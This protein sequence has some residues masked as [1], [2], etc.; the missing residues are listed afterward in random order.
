MRPAPTKPT[1]ISSSGFIGARGTGPD[2]PFRTKVSSA[3][4]R[5]CNAKQEGDRVRR[6]LQGAVGRLVDHGYA[7][8]LRRLQVDRVDAHTGAPDHPDARRQR[9]DVRRPQRLKGDYDPEGPGGD[10]GQ[11]ARVGKV[12]ETEVHLAE[13]F[14]NPV[15]VAENAFG[16][17]DHGPVH[18]LVCRG[19]HEHVLNR[20]RPPPG[21]SALSLG[22]MKMAV[23]L[24]S[25]TMLTVDEGRAA[26]KAP[27]ASE[28]LGKGRPGHR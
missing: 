12:A 17:D 11:P 18:A 3:H 21:A 2:H 10:L 13:M 28:Q 1:T 4:T 25:G 5:R 16:H 20:H 8:R 9:G 23:W 27:P 14:D 24:P 22:Q 7:R 6:H 19:R 26:G 15:G